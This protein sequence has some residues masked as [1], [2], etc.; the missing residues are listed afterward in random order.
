MQ[1]CGS[2]IPAALLTVFAINPPDNESE[3]L[4]L[5][6]LCFGALGTE[7]FP[8]RHPLT[9]SP[10]PPLLPACNA[11]SP[12]S[13]WRGIFKLYNLNLKPCTAAASPA[14]STSCFLQRTAFPSHLAMSQQLC[15]GFIFPGST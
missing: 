11:Q 7:Y 15:V 13:P 8:E 12:Q 5:L 9:S 10:P 14:T 6:T 2:L 3:G 1:T 4:A